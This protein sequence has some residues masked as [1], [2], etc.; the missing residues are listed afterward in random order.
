MGFRL[1][2]I[3]PA[4]LLPLLLTMVSPGF[5]GLRDAPPTNFPGSRLC[6]AVD[7]WARG[8]EMA[9]TWRGS[10][11]LRPLSGRWVMAR[12]VPSTAISL[13]LSPAPR[14]FSWAH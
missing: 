3:F 10:L 8:W 5:P 1:E 13:Y 2:G 12:A 7:G 14:S 4:A 11:L 6:L 9:G